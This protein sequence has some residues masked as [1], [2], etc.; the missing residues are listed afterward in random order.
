MGGSGQRS[1]V[2]TSC[3]V[4][5]CPAEGEGEVGVW[6]VLRKVEWVAPAPGRFLAQRVS[7]ASSRAL[8]W[9]RGRVCPPRQGSFGRVA[10]RLNVRWPGCRGREQG[11]NRA[12]EALFTAPRPEGPGAPAW[13]CG[14][15]RL[16]LTEGCWTG[17]A[18]FSLLQK[19]EACAFLLPD[20]T[21]VCLSLCITRGAGSAGLCSKQPQHDREPDRTAHSGSPPQPC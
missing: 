12:E 18:R 21:A 13:F 17:K 8:P 11:G 2:G 6:P 3:N 10:Y 7:C 5:R 9:G 20:H 4:Q 19:T 14:E 1:S 16:P 15:D